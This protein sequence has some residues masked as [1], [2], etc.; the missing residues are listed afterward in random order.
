VFAQE[1]GI[2]CYL[3]MIHL[4]TCFLLTCILTIWEPQ[5]FLKNKKIKKIK[6]LL[7]HHHHLSHGAM[8]TRSKKNSEAKGEKI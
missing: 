2:F 6:G 8:M 1:N 7:L 3:L 5:T 4:I